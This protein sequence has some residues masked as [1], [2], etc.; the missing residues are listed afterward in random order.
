MSDWETISGPSKSDDG[1]E[2]VPSENISR[3]EFGMEPAQ[4]Q[5]STIGDWLKNKLNTSAQQM[6]TV[7][8]WLSNKGNNEADFKTR[9]L[10]SIKTTPKGKRE[11]LESVYGKGNV[12]MRPITSTEYADPNASMDTGYKVPATTGYQIQY[13]GPD[14]NWRPFDD[15]KFTPNDFADWVGPAA[16][17]IPNIGMAFVPGGQSIPAQMA[18]TAASRGVRQG[19]SALI[20]GR[21]YENPGIDVPLDVATQA[22]MTGVTGA[23]LK[24]VAGAYDYA[25]NIPTRTYLERSGKGVPQGQGAAGYSFKPEPVDPVA[26]AR[27]NAFEAQGIQPSYAQAAHTKMGQSLEKAGATG[28]SGSQKA[29]DFYNKEASKAVDNLDTIISGIGSKMD[30]AIAS[31]KIGSAF[32]KSRNAIVAARKLQ[33]DQAYGE[34]NRL[35][36]GK[37]FIPLENYVNALKEELANKSAAATGTQKSITSQVE[38]DLR[39]FANPVK[40]GDKIID[41]TPKPARL[42][43]LKALHNRLSSN[44]F[45]EGAEAASP[46]QAVSAKLKSALDSD[47]AQFAETQ[48]G[49]N[50]GSLIKQAWDNWG[51]ASEKLNKIT[52]TTIG[53]SLK[54]QDTVGIPDETIVD[55]ALKLKPSELRG[56]L[57]VLRKSDPKMYEQFPQLVLQNAKDKAKIV[58]TGTTT[59]TPNFSMK[60]F[61]NA[62]PK[63]DEAWKMIFRNP[64][65][66]KKVSDTQTIF[67]TYLESVGHGAPRE[68]ATELRSGAGNIGGLLDRGSGGSL[69]FLMRQAADLIGGST[70]AKKMFDQ[71]GV[72]ELMTLSKTQGK[73]IA[74]QT[75]LSRIIQKMQEQPNE[76][77]LYK[78]PMLDEYQ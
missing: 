49:N 20:P 78:V 55:R 21:D 60:M 7:G 27:V 71:K 46:V 70:I 36:N 52:K 41:W 39:L 75:A 37:P 44:A 65:L 67:Q 13:R 40:Q 26:Q 62:M 28:I 76:S 11:Y 23:A 19:I 51:D 63:D 72:Q 73:T 12:E 8:D 64:E 30:T 5:S 9:L 22:G 59:E 15:K 1:W 53:K 66:R 25:R 29:F 69:V 38:S 54:T 34:A 31:D 58:P 47:V 77:D 68:F 18:T 56:F 24:G 16:E 33:W 32:E 3:Q 48:P 57:A 4:P 35:T 14:G 17:I 42:V 6:P 74:L 61:L 43:D 2:T 10:A 45:I 50:A